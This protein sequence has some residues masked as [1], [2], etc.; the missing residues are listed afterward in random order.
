M[1]RRSTKERIAFAVVFAISAAVGLAVGF[2]GCGGGGGGG[3]GRETRVD[4]MGNAAITTVLLTPPRKDVANRVD[5]PL[6]VEF[7]PDAVATLTGFPYNLSTARAQALADALFPDVLTI[8]TQFESEYLDALDPGPP[9]PQNPSLAAPG[10]V[11]GEGFLPGAGLGRGLEDDVVDITFR[12]ILDNRAAGDAV[13]PQADT[14]AVNP[15]TGVPRGPKS[16]RFLLAPNAQFPN[17]GPA[18]FPYVGRPLPPP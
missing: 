17:R 1:T 2:P 8:D 6:D 5:P 10:F 13:S 4:R 11:A 9:D 3:G 7:R 16:G 15:A 18:A 12:I 14:T